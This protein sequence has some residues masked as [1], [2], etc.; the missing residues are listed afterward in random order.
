MHNVLSVHMVVC[1]SNHEMGRHEKNKWSTAVAMT[2]S[3]WRQIKKK[4]LVPDKPNLC[5][6]QTLSLVSK[7]LTKR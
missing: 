2:H 6:K 1:V 3:S 4:P 7:L 5:Q